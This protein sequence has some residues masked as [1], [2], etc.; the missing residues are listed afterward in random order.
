MYKIAVVGSRKFKN[1]N[2]M[3]SVLD[4]I[5]LKGNLGQIIS[6]GAYGADTL[7]E[8]YAKENG[9]TIIIYLAD[10]KRYGKG[11]GYIRNLKI[12]EACEYLIAFPMGGSKGTYHSIH[13]AKKLGKKV[14]V[15]D[16]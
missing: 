12:V 6:G 13:L 2:L 16:G 7:A 10:W 14:L 11:A 5:L 3:K 4:I 9:I 15:I 1:F 8:R